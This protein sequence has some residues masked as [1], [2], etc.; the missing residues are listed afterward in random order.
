[1]PLHTKAPC[2]MK[3][4]KNLKL[5]FFCLP[6]SPSL[7]ICQHIYMNNIYFGVMPGL[8]STDTEILWLKHFWLSWEHSACLKANAFNYWFCLFG[9]S[10]RFRFWMRS[11]EISHLIQFIIAVC[12]QVKSVELMDKRRILNETP[13][14]LKYLSFNV[15]EISV[16]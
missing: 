10:L 3:E 9:N 7:F 11:Y 13:W 5:S 8:C 14:G 1:M 15:H 12:S 2:T 4:R 16:S 6:P